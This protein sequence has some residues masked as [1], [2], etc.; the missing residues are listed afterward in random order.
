MKRLVNIDIISRLVEWEFP[1]TLNAILN[2]AV[3]CFAE[4]AQRPSSHIQMIL[5]NPSACSEADT[6]RFKIA[7]NGDH[8]QM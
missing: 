7:A 3:G 1:L 8:S 4:S 2:H 6:A 5:G